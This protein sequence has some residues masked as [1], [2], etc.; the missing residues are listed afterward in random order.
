[1]KFAII[2]PPQSGKSTLF[3]AITGQPPDPG[4]GAAERLATIN[5]PDARLDY[6]VV[7]RFLLPLYLFKNDL[8]GIDEYCDFVYAIDKLLVHRAY[9]EI[10]AYTHRVP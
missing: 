7:N 2:G 4:H 9:A 6:L 1:M 10:F 8:P 5:V 3:S